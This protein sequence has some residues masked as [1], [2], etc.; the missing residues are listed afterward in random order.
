MSSLSSPAV[1]LR[2]VDHGDY[3]LILTFF[4]PSRGRLS[5]IAKAAKK[6]AK[7]FSG[8]LELFSVLEIVCSY[9]RGKGLP[10]LQEAALKQGFA[11]IRG[12]LLRTAYASYWA[13]LISEWAEEGQPV[14]PLYKL[15]LH[16]LDRL[17]KGQGPP[18]EVSLLFQI[19]FLG[20]A[21]LA[22]NFSGC[23][24]CSRPIA[25]FNA[26]GCFFDMTGGTI[27]CDSCGPA[28]GRRLE[29]SKGTVR[30]LQWMQKGDLAQAERIRT[31]AL[32][33]EEGGRLLETFVPFH[34]GKEPK[35]LRFLR[36]IRG[37]VL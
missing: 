25:A 7:R 12:D 23:R 30:Q 13:Q 21:G 27:V 14:E 26:T 32:A 35:S 15:F 22:P 37:G 18:A 31:T 11:G 6:S 2:R 1:L 24:K 3:D 17:D 34:L 19:R 28:E 29:L 20:I 36:Q 4:T 5:A 9:G 8:V 16:C 10:V 33:M